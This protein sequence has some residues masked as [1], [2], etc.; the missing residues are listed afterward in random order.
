[1]VKGTPKDSVSESIIR[2]M[3]PSVIAATSIKF[4]SAFR[5]T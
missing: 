2:I 3:I 1:M 5:D 4:K